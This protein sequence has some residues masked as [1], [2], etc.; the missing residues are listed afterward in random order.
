MSK[1]AFFFTSS[2]PRKSQCHPKSVASNT[3]S[4]RFVHWCREYVYTPQPLWGLKARQWHR[5]EYNNRSKLSFFNF[6]PHWL[7]SILSEV[8]IKLYFA[9]VPPQHPQGPMVL[10]TP[11]C[12]Q[13][14][15]KNNIQIKVKM[16]CFISFYQYAPIDIHFQEQ[17]ACL[18]Q[19]Q[20]VINDNII[21]KETVHCTNITLELTPYGM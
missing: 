15:E 17:L 5:W 19:K 12:S 2:S 10:T 16:M 21:L 7:T 13:L 9:A 3:G 18:L 11:H 8:A 4:T 14:M 6:F 1:S 20:T